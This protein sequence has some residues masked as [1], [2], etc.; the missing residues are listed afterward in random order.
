MRLFGQHVGKTPISHR[1]FVQIGA[2]QHNAARSEPIIH[3]GA[4]KSPFCF[5]AAKQAP[6]PMDGR[7]EHGGTFSGFDAFDNHS[8]VAHAPADKTALAGESWRRALADYPI[9]LAAVLLTPSEIMMIVHAIEDGS[10]DNP[11]HPFDDPFPAGIG[12]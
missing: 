6:G 5:L 4:L 9:G 11:A 3:F 12:V 10:A 1:A 7:I 2:D 8:V